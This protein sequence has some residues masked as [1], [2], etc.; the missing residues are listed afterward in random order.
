VWLIHNN[1][2]SDCIVRHLRYRL[3]VVALRD[4]VNRRVVREV[5]GVCRFVPSRLGVSLS[6]RFC[7]PYCRRGGSKVSAW[8][9]GPSR[10]QEYC[11]VLSI[12]LSLPWFIYGARRRPLSPVQASQSGRCLVFP[13]LGSPVVPPPFGPRPVI[14]PV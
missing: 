7:D 9:P 3:P 2:L 14:I 10:F 5:S 1:K 11:F 8:P 6:R 4:G 12:V 13:P